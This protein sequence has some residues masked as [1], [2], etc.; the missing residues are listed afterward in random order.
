MRLLL[1]LLLACGGY[2]LWSTKETRCS[3]LLSN[4]LGCHVTIE[5]LSLGPTLSLKGVTFST[6]E[7][8]PPFFTAEA[9][10][11]RIYWSRLFQKP[12]CI[13]KLELINP[14]LSL[15]S[16]ERPFFFDRAESHLKLS[17]QHTWISPTHLSIEN[18]KPLSLKALSLKQLGGKAGLSPGETAHL[19]LQALIEQPA[20]STLQHAYHHQ[21]TPHSSVQPVSHAT[22]EHSL[23]PKLD[24]IR[25]H[26]SPLFS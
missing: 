4:Q 10:H 6:S 11:M 12:L 22:R 19:L 3:R 21:T 8:S 24:H 26:L 14:T 25:R 9:I 5:R 16:A 15:N 20:Q 7:E 2:W 18:Q 13:K 1:I 17:I 23:R